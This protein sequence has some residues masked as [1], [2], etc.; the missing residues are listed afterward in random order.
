MTTQYKEIP[1]SGLRVHPGYQRELDE[2]RVLKIVAE[3]DPRLLG[4][5]MIA[6]DDHQAPTWV[7]DGQHRLEALRRLGF[8]TAWAQI[9]PDTPQDQATL[10]VRAQEGRKNITPA[11]RHRAQLF[12]GEPKAKEIDEIVASFGYKLS[13]DA[14]AKNIRAVRAMYW[15]YER[16]GSTAVRRTMNVVTSAWANLASAFDDRVLKGLSLTLIAFP[17]LD[18]SMV[19]DALRNE[20]PR[21]LLMDSQARTRSVT[22]SNNHIELAR[23]FIKIINKHSGRR[24]RDP[25]TRHGRLRGTKPTKKAIAKANANGKTTTTVVTT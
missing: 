14:G 12:A 10:F 7:W 19:A 25:F 11:A 4:V 20:S 8:T 24:L 1:L 6:H 3:Y 17:D 18:T 21:A 22:G 2:G 15:M 9:S 5:L 16:G 13:N 23:S